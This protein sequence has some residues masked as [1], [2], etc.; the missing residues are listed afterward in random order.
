MYDIDIS[1]VKKGKRFY[2]S[3]LAVGALFL[4]IIGGILIFSYVKLISLD[5]KTISTR[6]EANLHHDEDGGTMYSPIYYYEV[7]GKS[8]SCSSRVSSSVNP[9]IENKT[10]YYNSKNPSDCMTEYSK[11]VNYILL[12]FLVLPIS[13]IAFAVVY[14]RK[15][16]KRVRKIQELNQKGKLIKN[17]PYHLENT[18]MSVNGVSIQRPV[19]DYVLPSGM[20]I[21]LYGDPRHDGK[22]FDADGMVD[23]VIDENNPDNY[24]IDFNINRL[25]G[26][27]PTDYFNTSSNL[28]QNN[29]ND[30]Y[31]QQNQK[32]Q[33]DSNA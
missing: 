4:L 9:G 24:F 17:L 16:N 27:L 1:N 13:F 18:G 2:F 6:V 31:Q 32:Q 30:I 10:V 19:V 29:L 23:L 14:I 7:N 3:F 33:N 26:N 5:S 8:Y 28:A 21:P 20:T 12:A 15:I 11:T 22:I 25:T